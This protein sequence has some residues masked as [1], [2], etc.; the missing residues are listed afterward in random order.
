MPHA[1]NQVAPALGGDFDGRGWG[2]A[3]AADDQLRWQAALAH[4]A[5][6]VAVPPVVADHLGTLV[7][8][9]LG[10]GGQE[11]RRRENLEIAV[12]LGIEPRAVNDHVAGR[13]QRHL[14]HSLRGRVERV[15]K[16]RGDPAMPRSPMS[17]SSTTRPSSLSHGRLGWVASAARQE[18]AWY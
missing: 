17:R 4:S 9:M 14:F 12:D 18:T 5:H 16:K 8:D 13:F 10:D 3:G 11:V 15:E 6:F 1:G 7:G 2:N